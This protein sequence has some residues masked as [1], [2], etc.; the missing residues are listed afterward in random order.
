MSPEQSQTLEKTLQPQ[1]RRHGAQVAKIAKAAKI[2]QTAEADT[3]PSKTKNREN[4][5][6]FFTIFAKQSQ[7]RFFHLSIWN[8]FEF[9]GHT[10]STNTQ[11]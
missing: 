9:R 10:K 1:K 11:L 6:I 5:K 8:N 7:S 3:N 4:Q 2:S